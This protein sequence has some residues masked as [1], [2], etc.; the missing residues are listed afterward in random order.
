RGLRTGTKPT[1]Y[2]SITPAMGTTYMTAITRAS[3]SQSLS[4]F[5]KMEGNCGVLR[6]LLVGV[7]QVCSIT[8]RTFPWAHFAA[9][10]KVSRRP[11]ESN[12]S[13]DFF[14]GG[15]SLR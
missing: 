11:V 5:S 10:P 3:G 8:Q 4:R 7:A 15:G 2:I 6:H 9:L 12:R 1:T 14:P 13:F